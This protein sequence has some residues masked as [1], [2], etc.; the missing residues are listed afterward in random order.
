MYNW[1]SFLPIDITLTPSHRS[2]KSWMRSG[3]FKH[4]VKNSAIMALTDQIYI[5]SDTSIEKFEREASQ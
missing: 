5:V 3:L 2:I 1:T 4:D